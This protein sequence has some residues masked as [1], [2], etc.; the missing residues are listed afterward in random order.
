M[1]S[2]RSFL[3]VLPVT[4]FS[5]FSFSVD[6]QLRR[7]AFE[8]LV[9]SSGVIPTT[10]KTLREFNTT[11]DRV[12]L[13]TVQEA[14][15]CTTVAAAKVLYDRAK[16]VMTTDSRL[17]LR[18]AG[19]DLDG[20]LPDAFSSKAIIQL[21]A[22]KGRPFIFKYPLDAEYHLE[23]IVKDF[24]FCDMVKAVNSGALPDGL[25]SYSDFTLV[26]SS[27]NLIRGSLSDV[28][29]FSLNKWQRPLS[30][31]FVVLL[32]RRLIR[33]L[34]AVHGL[35]FVI[36]DLKP[37]NVFVTREGLADIGDF[38]GA[39]RIGE[40]I[41]ECTPEYILE[42]HEELRQ[43]NPAVDWGCLVNTGL[44]LMGL[45]RGRT[46]ARLRDLMESIPPSHAEVSG[47]LRD[48]LRRM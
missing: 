7:S 12:F 29:A 15:A 48:V 10:P 3:L 27:G 22:I 4:H 43:A 9:H 21:V 23:S 33:T 34:D 46:V 19:I 36:V 32:L 25:V 14:N 18:D 42:E 44:D 1:R 24:T 13:Q 2:S 40:E 8:A 17:K 38:G 5:L 41:T 6:P 45:P 16:R 20:L 39:R 30:C 35:G 47:I 37:D 11:I 26:D 28:Y 31:T